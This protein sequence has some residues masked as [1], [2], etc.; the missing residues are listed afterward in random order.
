MLCMPKWR[1]LRFW[2]HA[3]RALRRCQHPLAGCRKGCLGCLIFLSLAA[4][5]LYTSEVYL[6]GYTGESARGEWRRWPDPLETK[7]A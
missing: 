2:R 5:R 1:C 6:E 3:E 4:A 7:N